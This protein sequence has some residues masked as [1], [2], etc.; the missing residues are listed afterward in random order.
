[1]SN[2]RVSASS[3]CASFKTISDW[4]RFC[5]SENEFHQ[6]FYGHGTDNAFDDAKY[7]VLGVLNLP[8]ELYELVCDN[9]LAEEEKQCLY[10]AGE[11]LF[12]R[13]PVPYITGTALYAG[14]EFL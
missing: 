9:Q 5:V 12:K 4:V 2:L 8:W 13:L 6:V 3:A 10:Q 1:M 7:L 11:T 14:L